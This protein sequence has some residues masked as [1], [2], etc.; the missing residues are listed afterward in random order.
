MADF[1][2]RHFGAVKRSRITFGKIANM[3][4]NNFRGYFN[5]CVTKVKKL[6]GFF[7]SGGKKAILPESSFGPTDVKSYWGHKIR[8]MSPVKFCFSGPIW[9]IW[10]KSLKFL[11]VLIFFSAY[12]LSNYMMGYIEKSQY[13]DLSLHTAA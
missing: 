11:P 3:N 2:V 5:R 9:L 4:N 7:K 8:V 13:P 12:Y 10:Q 1:F 6:V